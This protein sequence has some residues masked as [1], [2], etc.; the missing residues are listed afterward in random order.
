MT[1]RTRTLLMVS[2]LL[3][4]AVTAT[5]MALTWSARQALLVQAKAD[6]MV[7]ASLLARSAAF[8][9]RV[10]QDVEDAIGRQMIVEATISAH[11]VAIAEAAGLTPDEINDHLRQITAYTALDEFWITDETGHAYLRTKAETDF[12]FSPDPQQQPQAYVFWPLLTGEAQSVV[13]E[14]RRREIDDQVWKYAAVSGLDR[15]RIVQVGYPVGF[16]DQMREQM[17]LNRLVNELVVTGNV[18]AIRVIDGGFVTL[19]YG[20]APGAAVSTDL[21]PADESYLRTVLSKG[22]S[23]SYMDGPVLKVIAPISVAGQVVGAAVV[24]L[25]TDYVQATIQRQLLL[26][27]AL[28]VLVLAAGLLGSAFWARRVTHPVARLSAAAASVES[29]TYD[30]ESLAD[31]SARADELGQLARVFQN[32]ARQVY[33]REQSLKQKVQELQIEIDE[34]K[35]QRQVAEITETEYF[36]DLCA[37][38]QRLRRRDASNA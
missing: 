4:I 17:G 27:A 37:K 32:M 34:A 24:F 36:R 11:L 8:A 16:L 3:V 1:L 23:V 9:T 7:I 35:K 6:G 15:R 12:T 29:E 22:T 14:A 28:A 25:P 33:A 21:S 5:T 13:Q 30:P 38:A 20:V 2:V 18:V 31:V 10:P 26:A 19:A